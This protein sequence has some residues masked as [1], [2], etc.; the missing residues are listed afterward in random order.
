[1]VS[2]DWCMPCQQMKKD[3]LPKV[4]EDG[5]LS[6][7]SFAVVNP[8]T[9]R[10]LAQKLTGG[11]PVPAIAHVSQ[12]RSGLETSEAHRRPDGGRR[13]EFHPRG[14]VVGQARQATLGRSLHRRDRQQVDVRPSTSPVIGYRRLRSRSRA[15]WGLVHFSAERRGLREKRRPKTWTCPPPQRGLP[16]PG[17]SPVGPRPCRC[18]ISTARSAGVMPL[19]RPAWARLAGRIR[20]SFSRASARRWPSARSRS[21][22][23]CAGPPD[24]AA[25]RC[26]PLAGRC[27]RRTSRRN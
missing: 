7:V 1:M 19:M 13:E 2:T 3:V 17:Q 16:R 14:T 24:A 25:G 10:A 6:E 11:G 8:D 4:R 26:R 22:P 20:A 18:T 27:S 5:L 9:D 12:D 21:P 15:S 23:G